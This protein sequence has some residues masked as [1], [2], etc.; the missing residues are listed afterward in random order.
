MAVKPELNTVVPGEDRQQSHH[1]QCP[2]LL[3]AP[4]LH[5]AG[6]QAHAPQCAFFKPQW[7]SVE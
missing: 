1:P 7:Q 3:G 2:S 6:Q 5:G 4:Q